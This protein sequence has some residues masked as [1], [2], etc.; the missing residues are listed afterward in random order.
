MADFEP[1]SLAIEYECP[2][3]GPLV[4][5]LASIAPLF[6][7]LARELYPRGRAWTTD[8]ASTTA[9][10]LAT[11]AEVAAWVELQVSRLGDETDPRRTAA[12]IG[13]WERSLGL[14]D[15]CLGSGA[16][17]DVR[18]A[19]IET[20]L[21]GLQGASEPEV[22]AFLTSLGYSVTIE[23][24]KVCRF[25]SF[26]IGDALLDERWQFTVALHYWGA[27]DRALLR[28]ALSHRLPAHVVALFYFG[29]FEPAGVAVEDECPPMA[30][31]Y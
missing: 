6:R 24:F 27:G 8:P 18:R 20:R 23:R 28:C 5:E 16:N 26:E 17:I 9:R 14:P 12:L 4:D 25:E 11:I 1:A 31:I 15:E 7:G 29:E 2:P 22:L 30:T 3:I 19:A 13:E 10:L 21:I